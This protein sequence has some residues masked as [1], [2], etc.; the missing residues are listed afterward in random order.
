MNTDTLIMAV[1]L[2]ISNLITSLVTKATTK[3]KQSAEA[4]KLLT[5]AYNTL[6]EDLQKQIREMNMTTD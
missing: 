4:T 2:V 5:D 6:V 3:K 1:V